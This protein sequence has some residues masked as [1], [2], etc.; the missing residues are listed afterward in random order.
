MRTFAVLLALASAY[1]RAP[2]AQPKELMPAEAPPAEASGEP[3]II[4]DGF[5]RVGCVIDESPAG[6]RIPYDDGNMRRPRMSPTECFTFCRDKAGMRF[7]LIE[8]GRDCYCTEYYHDVTTGG[9]D[10]D[11][12]CEGDYDEMCG[13]KVKASTFEMHMCGKS[14]SRADAAIDSAAAEA[15]KAEAAAATGQAAFEAFEKI[16]AQWQLG[17][18]SKSAQVCDLSAHFQDAGQE[19]RDAAHRASAAAA[20]AHNASAAV[21][22]AKAAGFGTAEL[23]TALELS[24][25]AAG[26]AMRGAAVK[27][28]VV[29][30]ALKGLAGPLAQVPPLENWTSLFVTASTRKEW[31]AI[32]DLAPVEGMKFLMVNN[33]SADGPALCADVC[34]ATPIECVGFNYQ[35]VAGGFACQML[36][37]EGVFTPEGSLADAFGTFELSETKVGDLGY[38]QIDC[39]MKDAFLARNGGT[40]PE[41]LATVIKTAA[42]PVEEA[43]TRDPGLDL[44]A[45][46]VGRQAGVE[47]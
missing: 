4:A 36:S 34:V 46:T 41:V 42:V 21:A 12:P 32:C 26:E 16:S 3:A 1:L 7:F 14:A 6:V 11:L 10:C 35:A 15:A 44:K 47:R 31:H 13:G 43:P 39:F 37:N 2:A 45:P 29:G 28:E 38:E 5:S 17:I 8:H 40:K 18:C 30:M 24:I 20:E 25:E 33:G 19:V 27:G 23:A 9:G 22:A